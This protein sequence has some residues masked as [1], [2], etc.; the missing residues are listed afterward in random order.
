MHGACALMGGRQACIDA[1]VKFRDGASSIHLE[2]AGIA[3]LTGL[4]H[5]H[6]CRKDHFGWPQVRHA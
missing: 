3:E 6:D 4:G 1:N 5:V 2:D